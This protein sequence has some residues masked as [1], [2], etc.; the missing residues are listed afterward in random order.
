MEVVDQTVELLTLTEKGYGK[1]SPV[2]DYR[3]TKRGGS[4]VRTL[5]ITDKTGK[6][7]GTKP[8][9]DKD[10]LIITSKSGMV[11]RVP[12]YESDD[13]QIRSMGRSTQGVRIMRLEEGDRVMALA[14]IVASEEEEKVVEEAAESAQKPKM[15]DADFAGL[16]E[17][18]DDGNGAGGGEKAE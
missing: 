1:R 12:I 5:K 7:V 2:E 16:K 15:S 4:G 10:A 8:V 11:I 17:D 14:K 9:T 18:K 13:H 3:K 6:I